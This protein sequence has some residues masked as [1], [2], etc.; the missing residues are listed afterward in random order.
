MAT[1]CFMQ[2]FEGPE[3]AVH[4]TYVRIRGSRKHRDIIERLNRPINARQFPDWQMGFA[5]PAKSEL[6]ML[7]TARWA[8]MEQETLKSAATP[9]GLLLLK[10]FWQG[11][12]QH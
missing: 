1:A 6:L 11:A 5:Q 9:P 2:C 12:R 7:S 3:L 10:E 4:E 8:V